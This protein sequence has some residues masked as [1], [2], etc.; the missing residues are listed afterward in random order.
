[1]VDEADVTT[2]FAELDGR[3]VGVQLFNPAEESDDDLMTPPHCAE[4][5]AGAT[6]PEA[7]GLGVNVLLTQLGLAQM[8]A[9]GYT[10]CQTDWRVTNLLA[11]RHWPRRGFTPMVYRL[12]R[13]VDE[14]IVWAR[15]EE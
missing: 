13:H 1:M 14:R 7:R 12:F 6:R 9:E 2:W 8:R 10:T 15:A 11:S 3:L 4:L 5:G